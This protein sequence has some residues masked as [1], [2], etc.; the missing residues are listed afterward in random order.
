M[1]EDYEHITCPIYTFNIDIIEGEYLI[2]DDSIKATVLKVIELF[3]S[4]IENVAV[5]VCDSLDERQYARKRKFD[6]WF[7][8]SDSDLII[9]EDGIAKIE[10]VEILNSILIHKHNIQLNSLIKAFRELNG[11]DNN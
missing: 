7:N 11:F 10:G 9:K 4:S 2:L 5:Y 6:I 1:F 3:F 8:T